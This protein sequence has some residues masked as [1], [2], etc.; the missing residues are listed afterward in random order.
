MKVSVV[1]PSCNRWTSLKRCLA[2]LAIQTRL[3]DEVIVVENA[4]RKHYPIARS[5]FKNLKI[6]HVLE[7]T[8]GKSTTRNMGIMKAA[9]EII[10][11]LDDDCEPVTH[12]LE[13]ICEPFTQKK[14]VAALGV[15][16]E[17]VTSLLMETY[18]FQYEKFFL[19]LRID[20]STR[21]V[22]CGAALNT[23]NCA[24]RRKFLSEKN[25]AFDERYNEYLFAEDADF[26][27]QIE[28]AGGDMVY[29]PSAIVVHNEQA[30]FLSLIKKKFLNGRA[31]FVLQKKGIFHKRDVERNKS[32][33]IF[34]RISQLLEGKSLW[35]S[36]CVIFFLNS[37]FWSY[38]L[39]YNLE[40]MK[41]VFQRV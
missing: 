5:E 6:H 39:G 11:F 1:I 16:E 26:G 3:P 34:Q 41:H 24:V 12:W 33:R 27:E 9:G 4:V 17:K 13:K 22:T 29:S 18:L 23:R 28:K 8:P 40:R 30:N 15:S 31:M 7:K 32:L 36:I 14:I 2:A 25:I 38:R 19:Q 21:R 37:I 35:Q 10:A 20:K